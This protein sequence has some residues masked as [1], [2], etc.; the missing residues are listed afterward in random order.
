LREIGGEC[1]SAQ[2]KLPI[3]ISKDKVYLPAE[4]KASSHILKPQIRGFA[5]TAHNEAFCMMLAKR[6]FSPALRIPGVSIWHGERGVELDA[7]VIERYD[8]EKL[9][10]GRIRRIHQE[11]FCQALGCPADQK[12]ENEGGP[13]LKECSSLHSAYNRLWRAASAQMGCL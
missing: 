10:D 9:K 4:N 12:Y 7:M 2:D 3:Y 8:R 1:A 5:D 11:D 6:I 13:G